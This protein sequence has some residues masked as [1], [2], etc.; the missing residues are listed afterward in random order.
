MLS[1][2]PFTQRALPLCKTGWQLTLELDLF[3][4][5]MVILIGCVEGKQGGWGQNVSA[6]PIL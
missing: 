3:S 6:N 1:K 4:L 2:E 5:R